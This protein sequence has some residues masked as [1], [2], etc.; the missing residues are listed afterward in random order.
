MS[1]FISLQFFELRIL[2]G[3]FFTGLLSSFLGALCPLLLNRTLSNLTSH[4]IAQGYSQQ[5]P[6]QVPAELRTESEPLS[7][8]RAGWL[9]LHYTFLWSIALLVPA[10]FFSGELGHISRNCYVLDV[11][12][13]WA[14]LFG[15][16]FGHWV[17]LV[18]SLLL[19]R[20]TSPI[21]T[22]FLFLPN[23]AIQIVILSYTKLKL[24]C[25][26]ALWICLW[27]GFGYLKGIRSVKSNNRS[28]HTRAICLPLWSAIT[29]ITV[30]IGILCLL[31]QLPTTLINIRNSRS[32]SAA[33]YPLVQWVNRPANN[34][35]V[36]DDYLGPRPH[37]DTVANMALL[38]TK[39]R[40][41]YAATDTDHDGVECLKYLAIGESEYYFLPGE[42]YNLRASE[43]NPTNA[44]YANSD[45]HENTL[46]SYKSSASILPSSELRL[47]VCPGPIIPFHIYWMG[48]A[49]WRVELF[50]KSYLY[51]QNLACSRLWVW[52]DIDRNPN[53]VAEMY[54]D[55]AFKHFEPLIRR[56]DIA[57]KE[58]KYP[59]RV[60]LPKDASR[61][62]RTG[63]FKDSTNSVVN[64][65]TRLADEV[66]ED[67]DGQLWLTIRPDQMPFLPDFMSDTARFVIL[68]LYG[69]LWVDIDVILL[70]DMRPL[71][72]PDPKTRSHAFAEQ[73]VERSHV[74]DYNSAVVGMGANSS[75]S[76]F[77]L[78]GGVRMGM[79]FCPKTLGQMTWKENR[80]QDWWMLDTAAF[81]PST[82][83]INFRS[84]RRKCSV[85]CHQHYSD[86]FKGKKGA[87]KNEW[88][89]FEEDSVPQQIVAPSTKREHLNHTIYIPMGDPYP[90]NNRTLQNFFRGAWGYHIHN[91]VFSML[92]N[93]V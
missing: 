72:L 82:P 17:L 79:N 40:E 52:L 27:F 93:G 28:S 16:C 70:R 25:H 3:N 83:T 57:L 33:G 78:H 64:G 10:T 47:G 71:M 74:S 42:G 65:T 30:T 43:Q 37:V 8:I 48:P 4:P 49:S 6:K 85:P 68:H 38:S 23:S 41:F 81:D 31:Y 13:F 36:Q 50:I 39:C 32:I 87:L 66:I 15:S 62:D 24:G 46:S 77:I 26:I 45:G 9:T 69:G 22:V 1:L 75:L 19:T 67:A 58:W 90:P 12:Q 21:T 89:A 80:T 7:E 20:A 88:R 34:V 55:P 11:K 51:T 63:F 2:P 73:W 86:V 44:K 56:G 61:L 54:Q 35:Q 14:I 29:G 91:Q 59:S 84:R 53:A 18:S 76:T 92:H 60:P 5:N